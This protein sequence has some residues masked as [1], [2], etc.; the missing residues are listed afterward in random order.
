[1]MERE[2]IQGPPEEYD[3]SVFSKPP[4]ALILLI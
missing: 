2:A 4:S 1:M 3:F